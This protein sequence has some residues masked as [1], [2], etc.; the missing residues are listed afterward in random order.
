MNYKA[1]AQRGVYATPVKRN[2]RQ[3]LSGM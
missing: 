2:G 3:C 1:H